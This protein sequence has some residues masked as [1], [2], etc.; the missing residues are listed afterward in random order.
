MGSAASQTSTCGPPIAYALGRAVGPRARRVP[1]ARSSSGQ[2][3]RRSGGMLVA[4]LAA[5]AASLGADVLVAGVLPTPALAFLAGSGSFAAGVMV[6]ASHNPADDNGLKVLDSRGLK[7]DD[8]AEDALEQLIWRTEELG[9]PRNAAIGRVADDPELLAR[10]R[11]ERH[12]PRADDHLRPP[13]RPRLRE[14]VRRGDGA[15]HPGRDR[16]ARRRHPQRAG[17]R[18]HQRRLRGDRPVL[19]CCRGPG[20]GRR[21]RLRPRRGRGPP[22]RRRPARPGRRRGPGPRRRAPSIASSAVPCPA[23]SSS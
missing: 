8:P 17:R 10:Y 3:T 14:R 16:G 21:P 2:D 22:R 4:A 13:Y 9:G 7:L 11:E 20:P 6:S 1:A 5:G 15:R 19:P 12:A 23:G 18:E